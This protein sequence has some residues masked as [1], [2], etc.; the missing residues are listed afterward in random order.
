MLAR[1]LN[2]VIHGKHPCLD[3]RGAIFLPAL[4]QR[5]RARRFAL[6]QDCAILFRGIRYDAFAKDISATGL[7]LTNAPPLILKHPIDVELKG[8]RRLSGTVVWVKDG[9]VGVEFLTL[10]PPNDPLLAA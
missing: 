10:L 7:G 8:G 5:R 3:P 4:P 1:L 6:L 2:A 9:K